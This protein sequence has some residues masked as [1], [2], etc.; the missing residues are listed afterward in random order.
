V[1]ITGGLL[2]LIYGLTTAAQRGWGRPEVVAALVA[3][4]ALLSA[5]FVV[6]SRAAQP[7]VSLRVLRRRT[8]AW[9]NLGGLITFAMMTTVIFLGTLYLQ[10]VRSYS[11]LATGLIFG[12]LGLAAALGGVAAPKALSR[13]G[14]RIVLP[15]GLLVQGALT[16]AVATLGI[17]DGV[18]LILI[19]GAVAC[20]G[21]MHAIV[22][23]GVAATSRLSD[24]EQG[25]A[26][27]LV[28]TAQQVGI[29]V[30]IPLLSA[31]ASWRV[32][33]LRAAG[34]GF[35]AATL[36]GVRGWPRTPLWCWRPRCS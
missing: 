4:V 9:G 35:A 20:F 11:P 19:A 15:A 6:E 1:T 25:L 10:Q 16:A 36:G 22:S 31:L 7:L 17:G 12:V 32:G 27:G 28:T 33:S 18:L 23:Y 26:T 8:V 29:T 14:A 34:H 3:A 24:R 5:F 21:H 2:T 30:G 13:Y